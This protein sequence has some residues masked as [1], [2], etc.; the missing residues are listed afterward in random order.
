MEVSHRYLFPPVIHPMGEDFAGQVSN[1]GISPSRVYWL[2]QM[3]TENFCWIGDTGP[4][5][6]VLG[7]ISRKEN[8][9][10]PPIAQ[11]AQAFYTRNFEMH[12]LRHVFVQYVVNNET[13]PFI[14]R[15]LYTEQARP[16]LKWPKEEPEIWEYNTPEYDGILGS[17]I[18]K[19][20]AY[21]ALGAFPRGTRRISQ[22]VTWAADPS[23][24]DNRLQMRFDI[25]LIST[26]GMDL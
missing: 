9:N 12:T 2:L 7:A 3:R 8:S 22:I 15:C 18:G 24:Y 19:N 17:R 5:V 20:V 26:G 21:L 14:R 6:I 10:A 11:L 1:L 4:G 16:E 25:G 23:I 13:N